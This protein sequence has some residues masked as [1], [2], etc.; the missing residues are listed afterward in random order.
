M[1]KIALC[2]ESAVFRNT[3]K[4]MIQ[5][6]EKSGLVAVFYE[7]HSLEELLNDACQLCDLLFLTLDLH[8]KSDIEKIVRYRKYNK[9]AVIV[10]SSACENLPVEV[11][12][13]KPF[14]YVPAK[15]KYY[16]LEKEM[17]EVLREMAEASVIPY[18]SVTSDGKVYRIAEKSVLYISVAKRGSVIHRFPCCITSEIYCKETVR[19]LFEKLNEHGFVY[20]HNSYIVNMEN[21]IMLNKTQ[22]ILKD[23]TELNI[24][25]SKK[26]QFDQ[27]FS[28]F[29][30]LR[31]NRTVN[32]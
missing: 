10:L 15:R 20:A 29:L 16:V 12:K 21:I 18:L 32:L 9:S 5:Q 8:R 31:Y 11:L 24:S 30:S 22:I 19:E 4:G 17:P 25:R 26:K 3:V 1:Y 2:D 23:Y 13:I 6:Y 28:T 14:C 7:Y 27:Y